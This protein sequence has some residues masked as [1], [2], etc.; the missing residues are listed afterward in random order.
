M[1]CAKIASGV[2]FSCPPP[3]A[4]VDADQIVLFNWDDVDRDTNTPTKATLTSISTLGSP[5]ALGYVYE[6]VN[7]SVQPTY[8][9]ID[10]GFN[11]YKFNHNLVFRIFA[12]SD[13][14]ADLE[15]DLQSGLFV[16]VYFTKSKRVK[17]MGWQVG[18]KATVTRNYFEEDGAALVT[19]ATK[20]D[21]FETAVPLDYVGSASP[22]ADFETLKA[23]II[24]LT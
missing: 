19:L 3:P 11:P 6:G 15:T 13:T 8:E 24:A 4:G 1:S 12:D 5:A 7:N 10:E 17:V 20:G 2:T 14:I 16:A 23:Q 9:G 22:T 18:L 21:E